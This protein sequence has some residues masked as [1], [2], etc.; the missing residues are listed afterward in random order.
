MQFDSY[1]PLNQSK[2]YLRSL[3]P[4]STILVLTFLIL[5]FGLSG[6]SLGYAKVSRVS[7]NGLTVDVRWSDGDSFRITSGKYR[8]DRARLMGYN[9]LESYGPV[10][11]WGDW[12]PWGLYKV[13]KDAKKVAQTEVWDCVAQ[14]ERDRYKR[15]LVRCPDLT[16]AMIKSGYGHLFELGQD[17]HFDDLKLQKIAMETKQ[18]MWK[19]G[20]P[21]VV[22]TSVH[23][24]DEGSDKITYNRFVKT[25]TGQA[26]K[27][28]HTNQVKSCQWVCHQGACLLY[29]P[30]KQR[31]GD[32]R[33]DCLKWNPTP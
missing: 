27:F 21:A 8:G 9:T 18:G 23:S 1:N 3:L 14:E 5:T 30:F 7:I 6:L 24:I 25:T 20:A 22:L 31:Y 4:F 10:H 12:N 17:P 19:R 13:A 32:R 33:P 16:K 29:V 2:F 26:E 11:K 15:L 28:H